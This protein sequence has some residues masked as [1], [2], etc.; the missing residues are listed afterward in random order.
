MRGRPI[1]D[2]KTLSD[3]GPSVKDQ[4]RFHYVLQQCARTD[5]FNAQSFMLLFFVISVNDPNLE[6]SSLAESPRR[7]TFTIS[8]CTYQ[9]A[10]VVHVREYKKRDIF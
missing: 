4:H 6:N 9:A 5:N 8:G 2:V 1:I 10:C 7:F 3:T